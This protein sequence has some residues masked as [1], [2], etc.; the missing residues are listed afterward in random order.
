MSDLDERLKDIFDNC[1]GVTISGEFVGRVEEATKD[2]KRAFK[3]DGWIKLPLIRGVKIESEMD[4]LRLLEQENRFMREKSINSMTGKEWY[5]RFMKSLPPQGDDRYVLTDNNS[6]ID[7]FEVNMAA[8]KAA[9][10]E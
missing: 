1:F 5:D 6:K 2:I 7:I 8:K 4:I 9:G 3:D 10:I